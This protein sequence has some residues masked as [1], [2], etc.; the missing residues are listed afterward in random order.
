MAARP[1]ARTRV[2]FAVWIHHPPLRVSA[3]LGQKKA[4]TLPFRD[5][6]ACLWAGRPVRATFSL[7]H[8]AAANKKADPDV[9]IWKSAHVPAGLLPLKEALRIICN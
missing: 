3:A 6:L 7:A 2:L 9:L 5:K 4:S 1:E 8:L